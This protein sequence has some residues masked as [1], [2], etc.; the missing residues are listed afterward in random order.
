[1]SIVDRTFAT[2]NSIHLGAILTVLLLSFALADRINREKNAR[3]DAQQSAIDNL[4][5]YR[6]IYENSLEGMFRVSF[7]GKL[8]AC[9]PAFAELMGAE[10]ESDIL[11]RGNNLSGYIPST[12]TACDEVTSTLHKVGHVFGF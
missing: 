1:M 3:E 4:E 7:D 12:K 10:S 11:Q 8:L 9:N 2:E 6:L 5:K